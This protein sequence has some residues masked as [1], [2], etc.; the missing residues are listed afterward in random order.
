MSKRLS[1]LDVPQQK[2]L[3]GRGEQVAM[4]R[5]SGWLKGLAGLAV[6]AALAV[7]LA[8]LF[9]RATSPMQTPSQGR[10]A[11]SPIETPV[12]TA[13]GEMVPTP[14]Q[15][16]P[17]QVLQSP[18]ETPTPLPTPTLWPTPTP[19]HTP[20]L[21]P[22]PTP[23]PT[24]FVT[25]VP[26]TAPPIIPGLENREERPFWIYY[27]QDNEIWRV[28]SDGQDRGLLL[29]T[30]QRLGQ[31][32]TE[33]PDRYRNTGFWA[34]PRVAVSPGGQ[35]LALVV[36][37]KI[38]LADRDDPVTFSIYVFDV[39]TGALEF[40]A[41]GIRPVWSP[42]GRHVV[43]LKQMMG[44]LWIA[45]L[46]SGQVRER[47]EKHEKGYTRIAEYAWSPDNTQIAYLYSEGLYQRIPEI[48]LAGVDDDTPPRQ[49]MSL[50]QCIAIL[51][52]TWSPDGQ[53]IFYRSPEGAKD[54]SEYHSI[55]NLWS[56]SLAT[57][58]RTQLTHDMRVGGFSVLPD[59]Q[60]LAFSGYHNYEWGDQDYGRDL[61]VMSL[62][63]R[64]LRRITANPSWGIVGWSP[65][66]TRL[67]ALRTNESP[68]LLSLKDGNRDVLGVDP[69]VGFGIG[70]AK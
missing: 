45:D 40:L 50:D 37:D 62:D 38:K 48:W 57:G 26:T 35:K 17:A 69:N 33:I 28:D 66:G 41:K 8:V 63:G 56:V 7:L 9:G 70:G 65:D 5:I 32:L 6:L 1:R 24:P 68:L 19:W 15:E 22:F 60:W 61:W 53:Q 10:Q 27:W 20:T 67:V 13:T 2:R 21:P 25:P 16:Q 36:V 52:L 55:S 44:G 14:T 31:W 18:I 54:T 3:S 30:Y 39:Q 29:D 23:I 12:S 59:G 58:E 11:A 34:G 47:I 43:F 4:K 49:L 42:D 46:E 64:D 51:G